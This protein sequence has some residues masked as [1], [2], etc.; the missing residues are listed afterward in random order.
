MSN[1]KIPNNAKGP[2]NDKE[3]KTIKGCGFNYLL[4]IIFR[5][6]AQK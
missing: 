1:Y 4:R 5:N 6:E 2:K 3:H